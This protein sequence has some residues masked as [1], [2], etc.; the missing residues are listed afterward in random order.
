M[1]RRIPITNIQITLIE[2]I[3]TRIIKSKL[4]CE[5]KNKK[6]IDNKI[7]NHKL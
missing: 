7:D 6:Y 2:Y 4:L 3:N 5:E 1:I